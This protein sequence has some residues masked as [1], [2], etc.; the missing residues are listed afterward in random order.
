MRAL[1][2]YLFVAAC[3]VAIISFVAVVCM[4]SQ[5]TFDKL[6]PLPDNQTFCI[7]E[8]EKV[9]R[10]ELTSFLVTSDAVILFYDAAGLVNVYSLNGEFQYGIQI[11][12]IDNGSGRIGFSNDLLY[13][14]ARGG[15]VYVFSK[16]E[17]I[18]TFIRKYD[19]E[20]YLSVEPI[21]NQNSCHR[22][23][24]NTYQYLEEANQIQRIDKDGELTTVISMPQKNGNV[25]SVA[26]IFLLSGAA[27][28]YLSEPI[29]RKRKKGVF[30]KT[31]EQL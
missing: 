5:E 24:D 7:L 30:N 8:T 23:G 29:S 31:E 11:V 12:R 16:S 14:E 3:I 22:N 21:L 26:M 18:D 4:V 1:Q 9:P 28:S 10:D 13:V 20:R 25:K 17:L 15:R 19:D 2:K 6:Q 27:A